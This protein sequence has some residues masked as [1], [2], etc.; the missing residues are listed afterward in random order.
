M[1]IAAQRVV[2]QYGGEALRNR[3]FAKTDMSLVNRLQKR[4]NDIAAE[5]GCELTEALRAARLETPWLHKALLV[6]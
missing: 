4:A 6:R 2:Q 5:Y 3:M 1:E